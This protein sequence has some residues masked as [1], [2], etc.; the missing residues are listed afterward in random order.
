[1]TSL[2]LTVE[3]RAELVALLNDDA[4]LDAEYPHVADYLD[5]MMQLPGSGDP[6]RDASFDLRVVHFLTGGAPAARNP[7]WEIVEPAVSRD[8]S[9]RRVVGG[10]SGSARVAYAE[11]VLQGVYAYAVPSP[12]TIE[13]VR[14]FA[15]GRPLVELGA[16]RGYWAAQLAAAGMTVD[17][18]DS[19][20]PNSAPN[21]SFPS[22]RGQH[23]VWYP[24]QDLATYAGVDKSRAVLFLCWPPGWGSSMASEALDEFERAGGDRLVFIG[25]EVG[26]KTGDDAFF[27]MLA[28]RWQLAAQD[29]EHISWPRN[30]DV[31]QGW[32]RK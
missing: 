17:A 10:E 14:E 19:E 7:Y 28:D 32:T 11:T 30:R 22:G 27:A 21:P 5:T 23:D 31:A 25:E 15:D 9:G 16:G 26:G 1:M 6:E 24:V 4:K 8:E 18:Y 20:P 3:R 12:E 29:T 13:W 2:V